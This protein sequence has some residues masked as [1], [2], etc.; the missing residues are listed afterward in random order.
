MGSILRLIWGV[1]S[2][3]EFDD[4]LVMIVSAASSSDA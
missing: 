4:R 1:L 2:Y 3:D